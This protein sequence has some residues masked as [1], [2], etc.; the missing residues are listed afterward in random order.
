MLT[1]GKREEALRR[2]QEAEETGAVKL[3]LELPH[4]TRLPP[5]LKRLISLQS[6]DLTISRTTHRPLYR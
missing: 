3:H 5:E 2:I 4:L 6:L 1:C